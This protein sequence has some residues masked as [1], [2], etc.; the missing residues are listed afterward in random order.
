MAASNILALKKE[1]GKLYTQLCA[2]LQQYTNFLPIESIILEMKQNPIRKRASL[3]ESE[4]NGKYN[5][6]TGILGSIEPNYAGQGYTILYIA[7]RKPD[8]TY[9]SYGDGIYVKIMP[10][11]YNDMS[12]P[13]SEL[14]TGKTFSVTLRGEYDSS[15]SLLECWCTDIR[16]CGVGYVNK[17]GKIFSAKE[18][19][20]HADTKIEQKVAEY[21]AAEY[22]KNNPVFSHQEQ[23]RLN[24]SLQK[25]T[26][27]RNKIASFQ[28]R[29]SAYGYYTMVLTNAGRVLVAGKLK[30]VTQAIIVEWRDITAVSSGDDHFVALRANGTVVAAGRNDMGQC[31]T[32]NYKFDENGWRDVIAISAGCDHTIALKSNSRVIST[33]DNDH[34]QCNVEGWR[35]IVAVSAGS[36]H[37]VGLKAD[38]TV[39]AVGQNEYGQCNLGSWRDIVAISAG[40]CHTV[41]LKANGTVVATGAEC[42]D[43]DWRKVVEKGQCNIQEWR[44]IVAISAGSSHTVGLKADGTVVAVGANSSGQCNVG[45]W[46]DIVSVSAGTSHTV[47]LKA[48]GTVVAVG[49]NDEQQCN[50]SLVA[51]WENLG[52][53]HHCGGDRAVLSGKCKSCGKKNY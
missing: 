8:N 35:D 42:D 12:T 40:G 41:G 39:V 51:M 31:S 49:R 26:S 22:K 48:D 45:N 7:R 14:S 3:E 25:L 33:G 4:D 50:V 28:S 11:E 24:S 10:N 16:N 43:E 44:D 17:S 36:V 13:V 15:Y 34:G 23:E 52:L 6:T 53:C 37:T 5:V 1:Y 9:Q 38:G 21:K 19:E 18:L 29:I 47:G 30:L 32:E 27:I 46:R 2:E 20:E